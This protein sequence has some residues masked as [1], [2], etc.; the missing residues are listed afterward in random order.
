M[1]STGDVVILSMKMRGKGGGLDAK[2]AAFKG[3]NSWPFVG[4][5]RLVYDAGHRTT[6]AVK[7]V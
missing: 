3:G 1:E 4:T 2:L 6:N 5:K 7:S